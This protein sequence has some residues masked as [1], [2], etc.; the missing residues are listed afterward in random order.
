MKKLK[1]DDGRWRLPEQS[2][3]SSERE[4]RFRDAMNALQELC[5]HRVDNAFSEQKF[6]GDPRGLYGAITVDAMHAIEEGILKYVCQILMAL[7][8][9][10]TKAELDEVVDLLLAQI[11][12]TQRK[13]FPRAN[14]T[15]GFSN[16]T[17]L[18]ATECGVR[19]YCVHLPHDSPLE[20]SNY[21]PQE[22]EIQGRERRDLRYLRQLR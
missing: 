11:K 4:K 19:R 10:T 21:F 14:F 12:S 16:L 8:T 6:G 5:A 22:E 1:D 2:V 15:K 18:S 13:F 9:D 3:L 7:C 17:L 20:A